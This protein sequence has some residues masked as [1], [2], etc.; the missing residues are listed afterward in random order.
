M[1]HTYY[2]EIR[3]VGIIFLFKLL[4]LFLLPLTGDEAYFIHW[5]HYPMAGYYDHPPMVGWIIY[6][7]SFIS[8]H[9]LFYRLFAVVALIIVAYVIF[10][11]A[12][13]HVTKEHAFLTALTFLAAPVDLLVIMITNDVPLLLFGSL[14]TL[15]LLYALE[16]TAWLRYALLSGLFLGLAFL[17]KYFAVFLMLG[18]L[19][20]ALIT[21]RSRALKTIAVI[22]AVVALFVAQNLYFNYHNCWNNILFNF[23]SRTTQSHFQ[24][25]S[26][27]SY[28]LILLYLITPWGL[29][30][31]LKARS[32]LK[33][34]NIV[35][36]CAA[37]L[38]VALS[39]F[40]IV[41]LKKSVGLHWLLLFVPYLFL[42][43]SLLPVDRL[44]NIVRFNARFTYMHAV[45]LI[46]VLLTPISLFQGHKKY[47]DAVLFTQPEA[48][49]HAVD[50]HNITHLFAYGYSMAAL[51]SYHCDRDVH[52]L[53]NTNKYGR[54]DDKLVDVKALANQTFS[55]LD[56][57]AF[58]AHDIALFE[59]TCKQAVIE[60][61][62]IHDATYH[63]ITCHQFNYA[64]YKKNI[65]DVIK[66]KYYTIPSWLPY[67][68]CYFLQ[69]YYP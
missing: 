66:E 4:I 31:L 11:I 50:E 33:K 10:R 2:K 43:F 57:R 14:G 5:A 61:L 44:Q 48:I 54:L 58:N 22:T 46:A 32:T 7:M 65:L 49:C 19:L 21:Y 25:K 6:L 39:I 38:A 35:N 9:Y 68:S 67:D 69:R 15:F 20:F 28:L 16:R 29:Y 13:L 18:L 63:L 17:S 53:Y 3:A 8:H 52:M 27:L 1:I 34:S 62:H 55:L 56:K 59:S 37:V 60:E 45:L 51:L 30:Y 23:I 36:L 64:A 26:V 41:A 40:F 24:L 47:A 42:L 12:L